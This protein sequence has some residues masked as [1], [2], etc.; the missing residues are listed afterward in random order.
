MKKFAAFD[1]DGTLIRW[2]L[3]HAIADSLVK[4]GH[5]DS[6]TFE[7]IREARM[8]WKTRTHV[9]AFKEYEHELVG[10]Y[11]KALTSITVAQ[12]TE[13][14]E[15]VF[16][17]YKD[18]VYTYTRGL[19]KQCKEESYVLFAISGSQKEIVKLI[20]DYYEFDDYSGSTYVQK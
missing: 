4:L 20:A 18:Q 10:L 9:E 3:Y 16:N 6:P 7:S 14:I 11:D 19:I 17:E 5:I 12:F 8:N 13:A 15:A 1:I 2:Q